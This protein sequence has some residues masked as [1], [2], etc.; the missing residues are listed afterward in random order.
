MLRKT[1]LVPRSGIVTQHSLADCVVNFGIDLRERFRCVLDP[2]LIQL[3]FEDFQ[4][5]SQS[6]AVTSISVLPP[7]A[8]AVRFKR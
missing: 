3:F 7:H 6:A 1:R 2:A 5:R 8:L 4:G